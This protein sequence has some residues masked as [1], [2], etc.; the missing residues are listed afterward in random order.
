[1]NDCRRP[2]GKKNT[3]LFLTREKHLEKIFRKFWK[4]FENL[5]FNDGDFQNFKEYLLI[6]IG[7]N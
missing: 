3:K 7:I 6:K 5:F 1:M 4:F 2:F